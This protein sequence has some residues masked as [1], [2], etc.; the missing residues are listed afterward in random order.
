M[1]ESHHESGLARETRGS[2]RER[3]PALLAAAVVVEGGWR[4]VVACAAYL[5][6]PYSVDYG[7]GTVLALVW[8][9]GEHRYF[10][11][12]DAYPLVHAIYPPLFPALVHAG[13]A[14]LGETS[15]W[16][17]RLLS[18]L[19]TLAVVLLLAVLLRGEGHRRLDAGLWATAFVLPWFVQT[20]APRGR[21]DLPALAFTV[22][23]L[24]LHRA[25]L[26]TGGRW[27]P[28]LA[29][30]LFALAFFTRHSAVWAPAAVLL[31]GVLD[32][33]RRRRAL[34][35]AA[36]A[37]ALFGGPLLALHVA[38]GG[39]STRHLFVYTV[40]V[41]Y[42]WDR[43]S[44]SAGQFAA[45]AA[46]PALLVVVA[47]VAAGPAALLRQGRTLAVYAVLA[48]GSFAAIAKSGAAQNYMI[49]PWLGLLLLASAAWRALAAA[50]ATARLR[51]LLLLAFALPSLVGRPYEQ[52][53]RPIRAPQNAWEFAELDRLMRAT[54]GPILSENLAA[55]VLAGRPVWAD[56]VNLPEMERN[57]HAN[58]S[59]L[60]A[61]C[62]AR[63]FRLVVEEY[64]LGAISGLEECLVRNYELKADLGRYRVLQPR[65]A[66]P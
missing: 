53:P 25:G 60:R 20:W 28:I 23:G 30:P 18:Q 56:V 46:G 12:V 38:T 45:V 42:E 16:L 37:A 41:G 6:S 34:A 58:L 50:P 49:E 33:A 64:R 24:A 63:R 19:A 59:P 36:L 4:L 61:D 22:A 51:L 44:Y 15:L 17:P 3:L 32:P 27:R 40:D 43:A 5:R 66:T 11:P 26:R 1:V 8:L 52:L 29:W 47:V 10:G 14:A 62:E 31:D 57:G 55:V 7:E 2:W 9:F 13:F 39:A 48:L 35:E 54:P 21:V 65:H